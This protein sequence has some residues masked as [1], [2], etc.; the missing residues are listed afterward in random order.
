MDIK[1][2]E[3]ILRFL[4]RIVNANPYVPTSM[5]QYQAQAY[6]LE[7]ELRQE[8]STE[9]PINELITGI[10]SKLTPKQKSYYSSLKWLLNDGP[11][12]EGKTYL[13]AIFFIEKA[14]TSGEWIEIFDHH[15]FLHN[16]R[17]LICI[18]KD[19]ISDFPKLTLEIRRSGN[20]TEIR[21]RKNSLIKKILLS[22]DPWGATRINFDYSKDK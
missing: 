5:D 1:L 4:Q 3:D 13:I 16:C 2:K 11:R 20:R 15:P 6:L 21:V 22:D 8:I 14:F 12:R 17:E 9:E 7:M 18:I 19:I 10:L